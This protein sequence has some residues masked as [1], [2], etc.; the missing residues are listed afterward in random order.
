MKSPFTTFQVSTFTD[1]DK[2]I[3]RLADKAVAVMKL[4]RMRLVPSFLQKALIVEPN[5][6][7]FPQYNI[8]VEDESMDDYVTSVSSQTKRKYHSSAR[9]KLVELLQN[10]TNDLVRIQ[11]LLLNPRTQKAASLIWKKIGSS[12]MQDH[13]QFVEDNAAPYQ[14]IIVHPESRVPRGGDAPISASGAIKLLDL[15]RTAEM[16]QLRLL[17]PDETKLLTSVEGLAKELRNG[18]KKSRKTTKPTKMKPTRPR[19]R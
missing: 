5:I 7:P 12:F 16:M 19:K 1:L 2:R 17:L 15:D 8:I 3:K 9:R 4:G 14:E 10:S 18:L 13:E 6:G 11:T